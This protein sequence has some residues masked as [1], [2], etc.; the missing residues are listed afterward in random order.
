MD[1]YP[2]DFWFYPRNYLMILEIQAALWNRTETDRDISNSL[3]QTMKRMLH[4]PFVAPLPS[5]EG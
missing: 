4:S 2:Y 3:I 5:E 1:Y